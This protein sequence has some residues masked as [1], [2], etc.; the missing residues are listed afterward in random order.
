MAAIPIGVFIMR[1]RHGIV[2]TI[3]ADAEKRSRSRWNQVHVPL[4][5]RVHDALETVTTIDRN[6]HI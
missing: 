4:E 3:P 1:C 2:I 6:M 5:N